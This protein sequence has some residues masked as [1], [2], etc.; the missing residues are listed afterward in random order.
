MGKKKTQSANLGTQRKINDK[1]FR[2]NASKT[3]L[4]TYIKHLHGL[5]LHKAVER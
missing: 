3:T 2:G 5:I 1:R 4:N